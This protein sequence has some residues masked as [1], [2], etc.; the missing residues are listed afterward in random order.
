MITRRFEWR[1]SGCTCTSEPLLYR[2]PRCAESAYE[3]DLDYE[4]IWNPATAEWELSADARAKMA[5]ENRCAARLARERRLLDE[6]AWADD[7]SIDWVE[8]PGDDEKAED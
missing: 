2:C 7:P 1:A 8:R 3:C 6:A 4:M 5:A